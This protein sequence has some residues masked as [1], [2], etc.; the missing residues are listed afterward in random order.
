MG[1]PTRQKFLAYANHEPQLFE[2]EERI[3][4]HTAEAASQK[5]RYCANYFWFRK[6]G[7]RHEMKYLAGWLCDQPELKNSDA[8]D[9]IYQYLYHLLPDCRHGDDLCW[10]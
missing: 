2:L 6:G 10:C 8:Y 1:V 7:F 4:A 3:K 5:G 9:V